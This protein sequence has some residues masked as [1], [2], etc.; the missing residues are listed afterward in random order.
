M[1]ATGT[2]RRPEL[3]VFDVNET[4]SDLSPM[5][6]RFE[7][8]GAPSYMSRLWF[9]SLLRDGFALTAA[10]GHPVFAEVAEDVLRACLYGFELT[11]PLDDAVRHVMAGFSELPVHPD[12]PEGVRAMHDA[13]LRLVTLSNGS[14]AVG[15]RLLRDAGVRSF[16]DD[17]L[18]VEDVGIWKPHSAA[19][20]YALDVCKTT[21]S[22]AMLVAVHPWDVD[23]ARRAGLMTAWVNRSGAAYP[24][25]FLAPDLEVASLPQ[26]AAALAGLDPH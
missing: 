21:A 7:D 11:R 5:G 25:S 18:S 4:L 2:L 9:A 13:G 23:G 17:L 12:V 22:L 19:Y 3:V 16:F 15:E 8:V 20:G 10:G 26:L 24:A 14:V 1:S 6:R